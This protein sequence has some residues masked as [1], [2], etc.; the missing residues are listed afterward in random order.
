MP[1]IDSPP[2]VHSFNVGPLT[3]S[4]TGP[5]TRNARGVWES[6]APTIIVVNPIA[7]H[8]VQGRD[9]DNLPEAVREREAVEAYTLVRVFAGSGFVDRLSYA[10]RSWLCSFVADYAQGQGGVFISLWT[11]EDG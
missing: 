1:L 2:L 3:L 4:R 11:L 8:N 9:R 6:P 10:G 7:V 5:P